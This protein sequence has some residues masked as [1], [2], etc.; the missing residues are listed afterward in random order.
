MPGVQHEQY[1]RGEFDQPDQAQ[2]QYVAGQLIKIPANRHGEHLE[3]AGGENSRQ[4]EGHE[5]AMVT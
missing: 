5:R 1:T 2:I 4:P 3:T